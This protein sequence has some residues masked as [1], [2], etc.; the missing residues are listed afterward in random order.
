MNMLSGIRSW[1]RRIR[2][3]HA[4]H[5]SAWSEAAI[6]GA[7]GY[8]NFERLAIGSLEPLT[9]KLTLTRGTGGLLL[10]TGFIPGTDLT[11]YLHGDEAQVAGPGVSYRGEQWDFDS[12]AKSVESL[13]S[14]V[15]GKLQSNNAFKI[16]VPRG[17][18]S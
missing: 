4:A 3:S 2:E 5:V 12:P 8:T 17:T 13:V 6:V 15:R 14:F 1:I 10:W 9:G 16:D 11:L 7:D 18:R